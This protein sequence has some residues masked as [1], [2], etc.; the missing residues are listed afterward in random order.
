MRP[1]FS[2]KMSSCQELVGSSILPG[3]THHSKKNDKPRSQ[4]NTGIRKKRA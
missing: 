2:G 4:Q 3:R 1:W